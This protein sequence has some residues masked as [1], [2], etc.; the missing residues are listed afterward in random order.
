MKGERRERTMWRKKIPAVCLPSR[1]VRVVYRIIVIDFFGFDN[2][3]GR[4]INKTG[5]L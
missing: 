5:Q 2:T 1:W 4:R 3:I